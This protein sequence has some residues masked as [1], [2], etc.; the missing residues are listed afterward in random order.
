[1]VANDIYVKAGFEIVA[2]T[3]IAYEQEFAFS[4]FSFN[5]FSYKGVFKIL[6]RFFITGCVKW[7]VDLRVIAI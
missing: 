6:D 2:I 1:M 5:L 4:E 3:L 7:V